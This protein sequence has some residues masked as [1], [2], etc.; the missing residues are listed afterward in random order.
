PPFRKDPPK[1]YMQM[2]LK[3]IDAPDWLVIDDTYQ[4]FYSARAKLLRQKK[5]EVIQIGP[6]GEDACEELLEM[7]VG[8]LVEQWPDYFEVSFKKGVKY[9][10]NKIMNETFT[11]AKP[12]TVDPLEICARLAMEDFNLL[13]YSP[14]L[15]E[16]LLVAS[17]TL[18]PAG[19]QMRTRISHSVTSLHD[20]VPSW[21]GKVSYP[22]EH[23]FK[24]IKPSSLMTRSSF[25]IQTRKQPE[26]RDLADFLFIQHGKDF[27]AGNMSNLQ[28][29]SIVVRR[30]RQTFRRLPRTGAVVFTVK[31]SLQDLEQVPREERPGL[32]AEIRAW[33]DEI[34]RFKGRDMWGTHVLGF[35]DR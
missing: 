23:Y 9:V 26:T 22:V 4:D 6:E 25:F 21:Q 17:A 2:G 15:K 31:T 27:F 19:W 34:G 28:P 3:K 32:A 11:L 24:R 5:N 35:C 1:D 7:V 10:Q 18:F 12:Y 20:P 13:L 16:H 33:P 30:E 14:F 29:G 8:H